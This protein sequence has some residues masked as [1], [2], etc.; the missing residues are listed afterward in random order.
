MTDTVAC[1]GTGSARHAE[2]N[3]PAGGGATRRTS[4]QSQSSLRASNAA[5]VACCTNGGIAVL[6]QLTASKNQYVFIVRAAV[7]ELMQWFA[8]KKYGVLL[9]MRSLMSVP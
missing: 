3:V 9:E 7:A 8:V 2:R 5:P 6:P 1:G 4:A